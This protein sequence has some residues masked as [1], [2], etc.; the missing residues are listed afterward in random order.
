M[1]LSHTRY[2]HVE[3]GLFAQIID[4]GDKIKDDLP[5]MPADHLNLCVANGITRSP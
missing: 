5:A 1:T 4:G 3:A 2:R